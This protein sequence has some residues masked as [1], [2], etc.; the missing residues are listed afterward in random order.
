MI[1][2]KLLI[3]LLI[4]ISFGEITPNKHSSHQHVIPSWPLASVSMD[5]S[6]AE[7]WN[8][9]DDLELSVISLA[10]LKYIMSNVRQIQHVLNLFR[11]VRKSSKRLEAF[12]NP[13]ILSQR[14]YKY[15]YLRIFRQYMYLQRLV[16]F[17]PRFKLVT[18]NLNFH[19]VLAKAQSD[20]NNIISK[21]ISNENSNLTG[22]H[23]Q[24]ENGE[25]KSIDVSIEDR[26]VD[27]TN[28]KNAN[29]QNLEYLKD[30]KNKT[31][32]TQFKN[33][34]ELEYI[35]EQI[36]SEIESTNDS[37]NLTLDEMSNIINSSSVRTRK[38]HRQTELDQNK[39]QILSEDMNE[40]WI[41]ENKNYDDDDDFM[42]DFIANLNRTE[43][44][45]AFQK[46][47][48]SIGKDTDASAVQNM[49]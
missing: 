23:S 25:R 14:L 6:N 2:F 34:T 16:G 21:T 27:Q 35:H 3:V 13:S 22:K 39:R 18:K 17:L 15:L 5:D 33:E 30:P 42:R 47:V 1:Y 12:G 10:N 4:V 32:I 40:I 41:P 38:S 36:N 7:N 37:N 46:L 43:M 19:Q 20:K 44:A 8:K 49:E 24:P 29:L 9:S 48:N 31:I 28:V 26:T 11:R 45:E